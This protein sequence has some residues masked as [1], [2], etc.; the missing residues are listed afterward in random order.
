MAVALEKNIGRRATQASCERMY[1]IVGALSELD[2]ENALLIGSP[3]SVNGMQRSLA[4]CD[5]EE[6]AE[7]MWVGK[8]VWKPVVRAANTFHVSFDISGQQTHITQ[9]ITTVA[10]YPASG[11]NKARDFKG[12]IGVN[13][14]GTVEGCD[15]QVPYMTFTINYTFA[16]DAVND[17]YIAKLTSTVGYVNSDTFHEFAAGSLLLTKVSGQQREDGNWDLSFGFSVSANK[18]S[19]TVGSITVASKKGWDYMW[20]FYTDQKVAIPGSSP[21]QNYVHKVPTSVYIEQ[22][23]PTSTYSD[24]GI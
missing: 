11:V 15:I 13:Q 22:V 23:F 14:D 4:D 6:F 24:L 7:N 12:T 9:S 10:K 8:V 20:V 16:E 19:F 21:T 3:D 18:T 17:A 1:H 2:A 5:V